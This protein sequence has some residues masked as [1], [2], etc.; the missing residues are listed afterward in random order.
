MPPIHRSRELARAHP[1]LA[2]LGATALAVALVELV[3]A[4][5]GGPVYRFLLWN[6]FLAWVPLPL[7]AAAYVA[8]RR[9]LGLTTIAPLFVGWLLFFPNAPYIVTD[10]IHFGRLG[11]RVPAE[12]DLATLV[13][14]AV[15]G[16]LVGF[17]SLYVIQ[18]VFWRRYGALAARAVVVGALVLAS[19][20]VYLGRVLRWNSWDAIASPKGVLADVLT[21]IVNP[22]DF[23]EAWAGIGLFAVF[24]VI[25]YASLLRLAG[26]GLPASD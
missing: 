4:L 19:V 6:L 7:A 9:E 25:S 15:A 24:L 22:L 12:L 8:Q 21:R 14:A 18:R 17:A 23:Q 16:L 13:A 3:G 20:G 2:V 11:D 5:S 26:R 1:W 10:L